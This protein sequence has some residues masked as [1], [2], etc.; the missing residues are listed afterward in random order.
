[1][2]A[3]PSGVSIR[4]PNLRQVRRGWVPAAEVE[5]TRSET[6]FPTISYLKAPFNSTFE[7]VYVLNNLNEVKDRLAFMLLVGSAYDASAAETSPAGPT[8]HPRYNFRLHSS[9]RS[10]Q[11]P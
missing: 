9:I 7:P 2:P 4:A 8:D 1:M 3:Q 10:K 6:D 5:L 11:E